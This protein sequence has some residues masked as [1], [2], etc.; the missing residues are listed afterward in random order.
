MDIKITDDGSIEKARKSLLEKHDLYRR[1]LKLQMWRVLTILEA[2]IMAKI[3]SNFTMRTGG[4]L[5]SIPSSKRVEEDGDKVKGF[6]GSS[7]PYA[8]IHEFGGIITPKRAKFL[9][10][11]VEENRREDG[12]PIVPE[13]SKPRL[14]P[15][16]KGGFLVMETAE[17]GE[18]LLPRF[19]LKE[20][21]RIKPR[22]YF[23][24]TVD[25]MRGRI[26]EEF[27][28]FISGVFKGKAE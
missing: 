12:L 16:K 1:G 14:I 8:A 26:A 6:L 25:K 4:L 28:M 9:K 18:A 20:S 21:V 17:E 15:L 19:I 23:G 27:S 10:F 7:M 13:V 22:P 5:N 24:P 3:R 11:P 2:G